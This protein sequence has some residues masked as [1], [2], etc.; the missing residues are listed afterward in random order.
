[1]ERLEYPAKKKRILA[2]SDKE[3][4]LVSDNWRHSIIETHEKATVLLI[5]YV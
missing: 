4:F 3:D 1:M 2:D 5:F